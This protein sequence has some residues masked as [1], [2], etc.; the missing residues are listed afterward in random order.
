VFGQLEAELVLFH[1]LFGTPAFGTVK[2]GDQR[3]PFVDTHLVDAVLVAVQRKGAAVTA[4]TL[5][6]DG[7]HDEIGG[8][9]VEWMMDGCHGATIPLNGPRLEKK[10]TCLLFQIVF[11]KRADCVAPQ[12]SNYP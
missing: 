3:L 8:E 12:Y 9:C 1:N 7:I 4:K 5:A 11:D 6:F 10:K 2:L